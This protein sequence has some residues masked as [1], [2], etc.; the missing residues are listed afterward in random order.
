[1]IEAFTQFEPYG[2]VYVTQAHSLKE[3]NR[4][5]HLLPP[6]QL[7]LSPSRQVLPVGGQVQVVERAGRV[8]PLLLRVPVAG[9]QAQ[10]DGTGRV[11]SAGAI[12]LHA[13]GENTSKWK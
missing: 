5:L 8:P 9:H 12:R 4:D 7:S 11:P 13:T 2:K 3:L 1:M 10:G 6:T